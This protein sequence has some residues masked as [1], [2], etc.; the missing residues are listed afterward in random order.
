MVPWDPRHLWFKPQGN[1]SLTHVKF[2]DGQ[3][4]FGGCLCWDILADPSSSLVI[5]RSPQ[6]LRC[7]LPASLL[8]QSNQQD[9][10]WAT[11][12]LTD[13]RQLSF[14]EVSQGLPHNTSA[15]SH[16][17]ELNHMA[18]PSCNRGWER[19]SLFWVNTGLLKVL[20][21][22]ARATGCSRLSGFPGVP[23]QEIES[24]LLCPTCLLRQRLLRTPGR[25]GLPFRGLSPCW[26]FGSAV[27]SVN[28]A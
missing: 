6:D 1:F 5:L 14:E 23:C 16:W 22:G 24:P 15:E 11:E 27:K 8:P 26:P 4:S 10:C 17:P 12:K 13:G 2:W 21:S 20:A 18:I 3:A 7:L 25:W 9:L 19:S 28:M